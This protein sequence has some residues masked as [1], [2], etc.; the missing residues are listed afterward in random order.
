MAFNNGGNRYSSLLQRLRGGKTSNGNSSALSQRAS[1]TFLHDIGKL[2]IVNESIDS[3]LKIMDWVPYQFDGREL[4]ELQTD[5]RFPE[6]RAIQHLHP[7]VGYEMAIRLIENGLIPRERG[8][9]IAEQILNHH[10]TDGAFKTSYPSGK[11]VLDGRDR[12]QV[13]GEFLTQIIDVAVAMLSDRPYRKRLGLE[14]IK[15]ELAKYLDN[16]KLLNFIFPV[17][18]IHSI[19]MLRAQIYHQ[20]LATLKQMEPFINSEPS[21]ESIVALI[22]NCQP[23]ISNEGVDLQTLINQVWETKHLEFTEEYIRGLGSEYYHDGR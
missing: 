21:K 23:A 4:Q 7:L 5:N 6:I 16:E 10:K 12:V 11:L 8:I 9:E 17:F 2:G 1:G 13:A 3:S 22:S 14:I 19:N 15:T 20:T 18:E